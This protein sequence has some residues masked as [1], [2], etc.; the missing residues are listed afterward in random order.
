MKNNQSLFLIVPLLLALTSIQIHTGGGQS[1][2]RE[3]N[4][5]QEAKKCMSCLQEFHTHDF[6][7]NNVKKTDCNHLMHDACLYKITDQSTGCP[8]CFN[9]VCNQPTDGLLIALR[10]SECKYI[11][12]LISQSFDPVRFIA[13]KIYINRINPN[14]S[15]CLQIFKGSVLFSALFLKQFCVVNYCLKTY[16][17]NNTIDGTLIDSEGLIEGFLEYCEQYSERIPETTKRIVLKIKNK[18]PF[19]DEETCCSKCIST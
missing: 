4:E 12:Q 14:D 18:E 10:N 5:E 17:E 13:Q 6:A 9:L 16:I 2:I 11:K 15:T 7:N 19:T 3:Y 8:L 1:R